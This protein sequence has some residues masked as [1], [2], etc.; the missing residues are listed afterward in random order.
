MSTLEEKKAMRL[1][2]MNTLYE[3]S[4]A[5]EEAEVE[6]GK[7]AEGMNLKLPSSLGLE[8][9][10]DHREYVKV[11]QFLEGEGLIRK[12]A[13][14][15]F[16]AVY[17]THKGIVE[18][19]RALDHGDEPTRYFPPAATVIHVGRDMVGNIQQA[20][21]GSTQSI[22]IVGEENRRDIQ[23]LIG[24][25]RS[26]LDQLGLGGTQRR[27]VEAELQTMEAQLSSPQP[28]ASIIKTSLQSTQRV[29]AG[30]AGSAAGSGLTALIGQALSSL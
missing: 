11:V 1:K 14:E 27:E 2:F 18:V 21:A 29:L 9:D 8:E 3:E 6:A 25:L 13:I 4:D 30:A 7:L 16:S 23:T 19:E 28:K 5:D 22:T 26:E 24:N 20:G 15:P 12:F 17:I 10:E